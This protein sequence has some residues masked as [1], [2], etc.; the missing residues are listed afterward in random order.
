MKS[1]SLLAGIIASLALCLAACGTGLM[2]A[3]PSASSPAS[4]HF[5]ADLASG[6]TLIEGVRITLTSAVK[7]KAITPA[8]AEAA[9]VQCKAFTSTL[10]ALRAAGESPSSQTAT[11]AT[12]V[13]IQALA[14]LVAA[15]EGASK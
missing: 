7:A 3:D 2:G 9:Q 12:V 8:K 4:S 6:Y 13:A 10:D 14:V 15:Q 11:S 1:R 5:K